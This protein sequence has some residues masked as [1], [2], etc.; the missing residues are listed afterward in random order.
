MHLYE[1]LYYMRYLKIQK[2]KMFYVYTIVE[3][4]NNQN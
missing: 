1:L 2:K 3:E 4:K